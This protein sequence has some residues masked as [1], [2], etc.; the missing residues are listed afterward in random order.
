[1][2]ALAF[3]TRQLQEVVLDLFFPRRCVGC[4]KSGEFLCVDC[5]R[6]LPRLLPPFCEKCAKPES[7]GGL[8]STCWGTQTAIDGIRSPFRFDGVVRNAI[9][10]LKYHNLKSL[11]GCLAEL[12]AEYFKANFIPAEVLVPVPL[13]A[14]ISS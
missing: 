9:H 2:I 11:A 6:K 8:C 10:D 13:S 5:V 3:L 4:G 12:L 14:R 1:M 7:S